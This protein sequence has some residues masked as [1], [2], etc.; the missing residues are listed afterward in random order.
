MS[1]GNGLGNGFKAIVASGEPS[2]EADLSVGR[3][4]FRCD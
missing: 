1:I 2:A 3:Y 4:Y